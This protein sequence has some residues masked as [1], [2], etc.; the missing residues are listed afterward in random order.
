MN[1]RVILATATLSLL[2]ACSGDSIEECSFARCDGVAPTGGTGGTGLILITRDNAE[3]VLREAWYGATSSAG[4][5]GFL[6]GTGVGTVA[7]GQVIVDPGGPTAYNCPTSGTFTVT[8]NVADPN[9]IST[10]DNITYVSSACDSGTGYIVDGEH[11]WDVASVLGDPLS[12]NFELAQL[13][14]FTDFQAND[15]AITT[16]LNGDHTAVIDTTTPGINSTTYSGSSLSIDENSA[17]ITMTGYSGSA[18]VGSA[19]TNDLFLDVA[20]NANSSLITG[21]FNYISMETIQQSSGQFA[22]DGILVAVG[23][24]GSQARIAIV[25][26]TSIRVEVDENGSQNYEVSTLMTWLEFFG[27]P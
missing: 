22:F 17:L 26:E 6:S 16:T 14:T 7:M 21:S 5:P 10:G 1:N 13:L 18:Q 12:G 4:I 8:G 20:G 19:T 3:N 24:N 11:I 9:T 15:G 23:L 27:T 2:A 25:D